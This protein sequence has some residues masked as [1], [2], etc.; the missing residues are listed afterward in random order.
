MD[1]LSKGTKILMKLE[2]DKLKEKLKDT[3]SIPSTERPAFETTVKRDVPILEDYEGTN[4]RLVYGNDGIIHTSKRITEFHK[5][6]RR[7]FVDDI[8]NEL[9][10]LGLKGSFKSTVKKA[11]EACTVTTEDG[12]DYNFDIL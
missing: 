7:E 2:S 12:I 4:H 11:D 10:A 5:F 1:K 3:K 6:Y 9:K 8:I